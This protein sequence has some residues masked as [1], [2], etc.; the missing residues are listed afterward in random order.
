MAS[1]KPK[2]ARIPVEN[3]RHRRH[4]RHRV[5]FRVTLSH[6]L[7]NDYARLGGHSRDLSVGGIGILLAA[8]LNGG[9]VVDLNF[10]IPGLHALWEVRAV[11]RYRSGYQYGLEFLSLSEEQRGRL[12]EI[13]KKS[14][15]V[16]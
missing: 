6:F 11:V 9:E 12:E 16:E 3:R 1:S 15:T 8:D 13:L 2:T 14:K 4:S 5:E 10:K 7:G